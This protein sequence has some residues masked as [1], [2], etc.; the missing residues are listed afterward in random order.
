EYLSAPI[1]TQDVRQILRRM[2]PSLSEGNAKVRP[3]LNGERAMAV[4]VKT[5]GRC[6]NVDEQKQP[7]AS[8]RGAKLTL[9]K[10]TIQRLGVKELSHIVGAGSTASCCVGCD[11]CAATG[12][13]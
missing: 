2:L 9:K 11:T 5:A 6:V 10:E 8:K 3:P 7:Q 4:V 1:L 12:T 13:G